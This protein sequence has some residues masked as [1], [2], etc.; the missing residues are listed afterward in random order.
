MSVL[1]AL[2]LDV[3]AT[4]RPE[5]RDYELRKRLVQVFNIMVKDIF[6]NFILFVTPFIFYWK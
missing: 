6:G 5:P 2:L 1:E 4:L 3:Y